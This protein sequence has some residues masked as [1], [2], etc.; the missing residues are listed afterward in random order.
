MHFIRKQTIHGENIDLVQ[1]RGSYYAKINHQPFDSY[2]VVCRIHFTEVD[3]TIIKDIR[4]YLPNGD[5]IDIY[6]EFDYLDANG[7]DTLN[8]ALKENLC[9]SIYYSHFQSK[10]KNVYYYEDIGFSFTYL[11][12]A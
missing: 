4:I 10:T 8:N 5:P 6:S 11:T 3:E 1:M 12:G 9:R 2:I 7:E